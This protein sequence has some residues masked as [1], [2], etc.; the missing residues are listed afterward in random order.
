MAIK[1]TL[2]P[3]FENKKKFKVLDVVAGF[4]HSFIHVEEF[5]ENTGESLGLRV[6]QVGYNYDEPNS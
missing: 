3:F 6:Y 1:P 2:I 4:D 5:D